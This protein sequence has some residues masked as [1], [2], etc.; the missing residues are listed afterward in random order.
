M[1]GWIFDT[2]VAS[3]VIRGDRR[4]I[5][6]RLVALPIS[7][8]VISSI[9]EGELLYG[10]AK[11]GYPATLS[12][13]VQEFLLRVD[14][15]P[16]DDDVTKIYADLRAACKAKGVTLAPLDLMIA[17]HAA[18]IDATLATR[19]KAFARVPHALR[20]EDWAERA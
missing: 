3:R 14:V 1:S 17:A 20:I 5:V 7:D 8:I 9:T 6:E 10:L 18:A 15:L 2:N 19:E 12:K 4:E 13:R 11:R 16:W